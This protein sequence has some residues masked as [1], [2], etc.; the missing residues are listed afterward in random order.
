MARKHGKT[1]TDEIRQAIL[2]GLQ[3]GSMQVGDKVPAVPKLMQQFDCARVTAA[4]ALKQ[5]QADGL[6]HTINGSGTYI[7]PPPRR[8]KIVV[9]HPPDREMTFGH[10]NIAAHLFSHG[11]AQACKTRFREHTLMDETYEDFLEHLDLAEVVYP[12]LRGVILFRGYGCVKQ[13]GPVLDAKGIPWLLYGSDLEKT[14]HCNRLIVNHSRI[15]EAAVNYLYSRGHE[16]IG[17]V[18]FPAHH[19]HIAVRREMPLALKK[20]HLELRPEHILQ[21][22]DAY[23]KDARYR[24][25][26]LLQLPPAERPT[27]LFCVVD[28]IAINVLTGL[29]LAGVKCPDDISVMGGENSPFIEDT[30]PPLTTLMQSWQEDG[31]TCVEQL[32]QAWNN[33]TAPVRLESEVRLIERES[34]ADLTRRTTTKHTKHTKHTKGKLKVVR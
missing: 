32:V 11:A 9:L 21:V 1:K 27:A 2:D 17:L 15:A 4:T 25:Q 30:E 14:T 22:E 7:C 12:G 3:A 26:T 5:L 19:V 6:V 33:P 24:I 31:A 18:Y 28:S 13:V 23:G 34:V 8:Y 16:R 29:H 10:Q 20:R